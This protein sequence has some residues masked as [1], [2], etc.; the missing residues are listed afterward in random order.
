MLITSLRQTSPEHVTV[1]L[2]DGGEIRATLGV[3]TEL[4]LFRGRELDSEALETLQTLAKEDGIIAMKEAS[5]NMV[6]IMNMIHQCGGD[7]AFYSGSDELTAP[8][9]AVGGMGT[10]SV[11]SNIAPALMRDMTHLPLEEAAALNLRA[12]PLIAALF[13]EVNPIPVKAA[14]A[15]L[16]LCEKELRLP[17]VPTRVT[18]L[19]KISA[20]LRDLRI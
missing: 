18:T 15:L 17:L 1:C 13:S 7:I 6:Q 5:G 19:Q 3:V 16:G 2:D 14:A 4:R 20:I 12:M 11:L 10:I 9:R 8:V